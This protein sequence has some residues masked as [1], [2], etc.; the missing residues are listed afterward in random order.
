M[1]KIVVCTD[2]A[3]RGNPGIASFGFAIY[4]GIDT[5]YEEGKYIGVTTNNVAEYT[6]VVEAF[7]WLKDNLN[8][9]NLEVEV[10]ADSNLVVQQLSG[11]FKI[12]TPHIKELIDKVKQVEV[13]FHKVTYHHVPRAA[14]KVA[15]RL[16]NIALDSL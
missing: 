9:E 13:L 15:D 6:A 16:A 1:E 10:R 2:G 8:A 7:R 3:S 5:L 4:K 14:N 12:K 11:R